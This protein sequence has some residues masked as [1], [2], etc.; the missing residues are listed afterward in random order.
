MAQIANASEIFP[1]SEG[2]KLSSNTIQE[3]LVVASSIPLAKQKETLNNNDEKSC[4]RSP[5]NNE[6]SSVNGTYNES[7][8]S[9]D[10]EDL[11]QEEEEHV[12]EDEENCDDDESNGDFEFDDAFDD[13]TMDFGDFGLEDPGTSTI[14]LKED[15][16]ENKRNDSPSQSCSSSV[17]KEQQ[18]MELFWKLCDMGFSRGN[19]FIIQRRLSYCNTGNAIYSMLFFL[20]KYSRT[21]SG[22]SA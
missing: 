11:N 7:K 16:E 10:N 4:I 1:S 18:K 19:I 8:G 12:E 17:N 6:T 20:L 22:G 21:H 2:T 13:E 15:T 9:K 3:D 5:N 14:E